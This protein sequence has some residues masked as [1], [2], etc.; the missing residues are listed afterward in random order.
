MTRYES[1]TELLVGLGY[2][3]ATAVLSVHEG[4]ADAAEALALDLAEGDPVI[5]L[6]RLRY[7]G[8]EPLVVSFNTLRRGSLPGPLAHRDWSGSLSSALEAHGHHIT[9]SAARISAADLPEAVEARHNLSGLGPWLLVHETCLTRTG[10]RVLYSQDYHRG[11]L[12][13]FSVL[14]R[15]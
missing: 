4:A 10:E 8:D 12:I 3:V 2:T 15:R 11:S 1:I 6:A 13:G 7:G 9:S 14:R 5:R